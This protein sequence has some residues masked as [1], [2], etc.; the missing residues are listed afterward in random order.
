MS[1]IAII[2]FHQA[3]GK[4]AQA[5]SIAT[6]LGALLERQSLLSNTFDELLFARD[7][8]VV[9]STSVDPNDTSN[10]VL[11]ARRERA[12][13]AIDRA[14][15]SVEETLATI[16]S[17]Q[18]TFDALLGAANDAVDASQDRMIELCGIPEGCG[19]LDLGDPECD[20]SPAAGLCGFK[21]T[22]GD[23]ETRAETMIRTAKEVIA[24]IEG[25]Q[26]EGLQ[27]VNLWES[28][29]ESPS[30]AGL[31]LLA[32]RAA[33]Q[34]Y[35]G[36]LAEREAAT[37][38]RTAEQKAI[39]AFTESI[40]DI[41]AARQ[42]QNTKVKAAV[43]GV[44]KIA[45]T[46]V[47]DR[48]EL[49]LSAI[50]KRTA[51]LAIRS[52]TMASWQSVNIAGNQVQIAALVAANTAEDV[53]AVAE[54]SA[55]L[56]ED[57][58]DASIEALPT[59]VGSSTDPSA[60]ARA[61][62]SASAN[63][64]VAAA[65]NAKVAARNA[66]GKA[67]LAAETSLIIQEALLA[68]LDNASEF[69]ALAVET[70][71]AI[72][73]IYGEFEILQND[74]AQS[75]LD[76]VVDELDRLA[77]YEV[78]IIEQQIEL[79]DRTAAILDRT[80]DDLGHSREV[81]QAELSMLAAL[82]NYHAVVASARQERANLEGVRSKK[83]ALNNIIG[84]PERFMTDA[85]K[86][87]E[88]DRQ[89][90]RAKRKLNDWLV[91][92]EYFAVRPFF[93]ERMAIALAK[94]SYELKKIGDRLDDLQAGCGGSVSSSYSEVSVRSDLLGYRESIQDRVTGTLLSPADR[95]K[96]T[97][98]RGVV[99]VNQRTRYTAGGILGDLLQ[100]PE[101]VLSASF[102]VALDDFANLAVTCNAKVMSVAIKLEGEGIGS[103]QPTVT[104][105]YE[106]SSQLYSCQPGI[107]DYVEAFGQGETAFDTITTFQISG[108]SGSPVAGINEMGSPNTSFSGLPLASRYT[109]LIDK[110]LG[111]NADIVWSKVTD[112]KLGLTY[113]YQDPFPSD[114]LC[115]SR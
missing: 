46:T 75:Q 72:A 115:G 1:A 57:S 8:E 76:F 100:R 34:D 5:A 41:L 20:T 71:L 70:D 108:R 96:E 50:D 22:R 65:E 104:L 85:S 23:Y 101:E 62:I 102:V 84:G 60:P 89:I 42:T 40:K 17:Q 38:A 68:G 87:A 11:G 97:L 19:P 99:P 3:A 4:A 111:G 74:V 6:G 48:E 15:T 58:R 110:E 81:A 86:L 16:F 39:D 37:R 56:A 7:G 114:S 92:L 36:A 35:A 67:R 26:N 47:T 33:A 9:I 112:I 45:N 12:L 49:V 51:L 109:I 106:G 44:M 66:A 91:A 52:V 78:L 30:E 88:A 24:K 73:D 54:N 21:Q 79:R 25:G 59:T 29:E 64:G 82:L 94:S 14:A 13:L 83:I 32:Y 55:D 10:D 69:A 93:N 18:L 95:F 31:A 105:L 61:S 2:Q 80:I 53:A 77:D 98:K 27:I 43:A 28:A 107:S 103:G 90:D 113:D 63:A